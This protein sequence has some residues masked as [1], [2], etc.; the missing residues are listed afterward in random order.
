[1][2]SRSTAAA[3]AA[4]LRHRLAREAALALAGSLLVAL[5]ARVQVPMWPVPMTLQSLAVLAI[6]LGCGARIA[7]ATLALYMLEGAAGLPVFASGGGLAYF[8]GPTAGYLFGF[9]AAAV[10]AGG[11]AD[12]GWAR[13]PA[14]GIA[15][16]LIGAALV[17]L[18]G[19]AWLAAHIGV[20]KAIA[21]GVLPF[22]LGD[23][24][25]SA[26]A[27]IAAAPAA[28]LLKALAAR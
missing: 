11:L 5:A 17:H 19:A 10:V 26:L 1:M 2:R 24:V 25:K 18:L 7:G 8:A 4:P 20:G 27:G 13:T 21:A 22:L 12:R 14:G 6:A 15:A 16:A 28:R 23:A 9:F 3:L